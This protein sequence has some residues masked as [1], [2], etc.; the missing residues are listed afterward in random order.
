MGDQKV[1][2][3]IGKGSAGRVQKQRGELLFER[4]HSSGLRM[5]ERS[6]QL[7]RSVVSDAGHGQVMTAM[8]YGCGGAGLR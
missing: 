4:Q 1:K 3:H 7:W 8:A 6:V 5:K 2:S